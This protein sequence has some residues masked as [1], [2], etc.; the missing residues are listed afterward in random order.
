MQDASKQVPQDHSRAQRVIVL[1]VLAHS[2]GLALAELRSELDDLAQDTV[3]DALAGLQTEGV[4][5][6]DQERVQASRCARR[7]DALSL[8][9]T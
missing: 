3:I 2:D 9:C 8:I 7:L 4:I 5:V 1:L 6:V